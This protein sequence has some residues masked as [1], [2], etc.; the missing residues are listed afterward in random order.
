M[1]GEP[2][3]VVPR[4]GAGSSLNV[5]GSRGQAAGRRVTEHLQQYERDDFLEINHVI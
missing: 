5:T 4:G 3:I 1:F 2:V